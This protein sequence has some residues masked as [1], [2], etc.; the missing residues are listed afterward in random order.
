M[1]DDALQK[2]MEIHSE[3]QDNIQK[4]FTEIN[5]KQEQIQRQEAKAKKE[6]RLAELAAEQWPL[7]DLNS[8]R[9]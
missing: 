3:S 2:L 5:N 7:A 4:F 9:G 8:T 6:K 1:M